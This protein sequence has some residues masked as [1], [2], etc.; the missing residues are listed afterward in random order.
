MSTPAGPK[1]AASRTA[2]AALTKCSRLSLRLEAP[3]ASSGE[4]RRRGSGLVFVSRF[5]ASEAVFVTRRRREAFSHSFRSLPRKQPVPRHQ[6]NW[7]TWFRRQDTVLFE[8]RSKAVCGQLRT[9]GPTIRIAPKRFGDNFEGQWSYNRFARTVLGDQ[10]REQ[11]PTIASLK[12][13]R[14]NCRQWSYNRFAS[15]AGLGTIETMVLQSLRSMRRAAT[16]KRCPRRASPVCYL[17]DEDVLEIVRRFMINSVQ[18][19]VAALA[20]RAS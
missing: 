8:H 14:D 7:S 15:K 17:S 10:L 5:Y 1:N 3:Q 11:C 4:T 20:A 19:H 12:R 6:S 18:G 13:S 9:N 16:K 2:T